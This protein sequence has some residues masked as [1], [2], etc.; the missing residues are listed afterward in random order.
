MFHVLL[1]YKIVPVQHPAV[2]VKVH[3]EVCKAL[4]LHGRILIG[5]DGINGTVAGTEESIRLYRSYMDGHRVFSA[6]DFKEH[7][8]A[9]NPFPRL[10]I[11]ERYEIVTTDD[12]ERFDFKKRA[13]HISADKLHRWFVEGKDM[14]IL[15]MRND[16]EWEIGRFKGSIKPP[17]KYFRDLKDHL[18][19]YKENFADK[20]VVTFCTG[21]IRCEPATAMLLQAGFVH[22]NLYQLEGGI[23]KY[24]ET[25]ANDGFYEGKCFV[26]DDRISVPVN[27]TKDAV[28]LGNCLLCEKNVDTYRNCANKFCNKLF[29]GCDACVAAYDNTCSRD[30]QELV[31]D[32][33]NIRPV[34]IHTQQLHRNK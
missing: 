11:K 18:A 34:R 1:Y 13:K 26:F 6:I 33:D 14:V 9:F 16:Y 19:W 27:T 8:N 24:A 28:I 29:I 3:K 21:G 22:D 31:K 12:R 7:T 4:N 5:K 17:M 30:C 23:V 15:D 25:Y 32:P 10:S 2:E 20:T